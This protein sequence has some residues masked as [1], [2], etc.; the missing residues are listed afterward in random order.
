MNRLLRILSCLPVAI[1]LATPVFAQGTL[2]VGTD[3]EDF[4]GTLPDRL[5]EFAVSGPVVG[6]GV[7]IPL[8]YHL[9]GIANGDGFLFAGDALTNTLRRINYDGSP[10]FAI[11]AGF[12]AGCCNEEMLVAVGTE[13]SGTGTLFHVHFS[14][15]VG[16]IQL[17]DPTTGAVVVTYPQ[18]DVVGMARVGTEIWISKW[19]ARAVGS[20]DPA[21]NTFVPVFNTA[22][23]AGAL[24][25]DPDSGTLW[26]GRQGG[27]VGPY[28]V[29]GVL[30]GPEF[31]PFGALDDTIDG[32]EFVCAPSITNASAGP[33]VLW[34][35]N[36]HMVDVTITYDAAG[37]TGA[38]IECSLSVSSNEP[39]NDVGDGNTSPDWEVVDATQVRLRA[40]RSGPGTG[41]IYTITITCTDALGQTTT[42]AVEVTV[43]HDQGQ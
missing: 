23:N 6:P 21:T 5:G 36:H 25:Y 26:V 1:L 9:N 27:L 29:T 12:P 2:F 42:Q 18:N 7:I 38:A 8:D 24:A 14:P 30:L 17:I 11:G 35:P 34:P 20:W 22:S 43:P 31:Q 33:N 39:V 13:I 19:S 32:L 28:D 15:T 40:E 10:F 37:C 41:R 4:A 16:N 3:D